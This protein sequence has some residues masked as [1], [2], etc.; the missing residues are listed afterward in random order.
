[1]AAAGFRNI[2]MEPMDVLWSGPE[3]GAAYFQEVIE[4]A[5][6]L[7]A[8]YAQLPP[9]ERAAYAGDVAEQAERLTVAKA[10]IAFPGRTWIATGSR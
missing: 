6:P 2:T 4:M 10:G 8:L 7:A 3:A 5:G 9:D 1:M